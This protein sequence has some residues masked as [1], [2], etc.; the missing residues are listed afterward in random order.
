MKGYVKLS[1]D[2]GLKL[3]ITCLNA[4]DKYEYKYE[5]YT[6]SS[7]FGLVKKEKK[8]CINTPHWYGYETALKREINSL[9]NMLNRED[10]VHLSLECYS[11]LVKLSKGDKR[12]NA[13]FILNY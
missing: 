13:A 10:P 9:M 3:C 8:H 11:E 12:A 1:Q 7:W 6:V 5:T 4:I 2:K